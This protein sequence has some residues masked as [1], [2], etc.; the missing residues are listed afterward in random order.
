M[1]QFLRDATPEILM[2]FLRFTTSY[3]RLPSGQSVSVNV[4]IEQTANKSPRSSTCSGVLHVSDSY[5]SYEEFKKLL[6]V[7]LDNGSVFDTQ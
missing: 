1:D 2:Q 3:S 4:Q 7:S 6:T 5:D